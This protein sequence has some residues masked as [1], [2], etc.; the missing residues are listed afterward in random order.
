MRLR[1]PV[2]RQRPIARIVA[3]RVVEKDRGVANPAANQQ[4]DPGVS[5]QPTGG[6]NGR[7]HRIARQHHNIHRR[8]RRLCGKII[9]RQPLAQAVGRRQRCIR[10]GWELLTHTRSF[11]AISSIKDV[12]PYHNPSPTASANKREGVTKKPPC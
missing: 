3:Y 6:I 5:R 9:Q 12:R 10:Q 2:D 7:D 8:R 1:A 4:R 11:H